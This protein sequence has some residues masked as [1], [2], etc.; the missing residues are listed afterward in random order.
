M[1][2]QRCWSIGADLWR[3]ISRNDTQHR[4]ATNTR[5]SMQENRKIC[6]STG[7]RLEPPSILM[8]KLQV[9]FLFSNVGF[10]FLLRLYYSTLAHNVPIDSGFEGSKKTNLTVRFS[11]CSSPR[12]LATFYG[13]HFGAK[14]SHIFHL[15]L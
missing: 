1:R 11:F 8:F 6:I 13:I 12:I 9:I 10:T 5:E 15:H 2:F 7:F 14:F 4:N 3:V